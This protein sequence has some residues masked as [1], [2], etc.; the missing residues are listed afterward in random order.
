MLMTLALQVRW[1][2]FA[3]AAGMASS[4]SAQGVVYRCPGP[5]VLY[6]DQITPAQAKEKN[7]RSIEGAPIS[8]VSPP[9]PRPAASPSSAGAAPAP[10]GDN[11]VDRNDQRARDSDARRILENELRQ[12][13][14]RLK[15]LELEYN[16]G[17][18]AR[19]AGDERNFE[20]YQER[21]AQLKAAVERKQSDIAAIRRELSKLNG[22]LSS[23]GPVSS[24]AKN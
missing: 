20:K 3:L 11:R 21:V 18:P 8:V 5:P 22:S 4:A 14:E 9:K 1:M 23:S 7:C 12:E 6:T 19:R 15:E 17:Q 16:S 10:S 2:L 13:E 24:G